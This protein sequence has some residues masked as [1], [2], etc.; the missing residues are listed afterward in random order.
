[1]SAEWAFVLYLLSAICFGLAVLIHFVPA[2]TEPRPAWPYTGILIP[3]GLLFFV[4][5]PLITAG[6]RL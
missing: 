2:R 6:A 5:V 4:L 1:M 3:L